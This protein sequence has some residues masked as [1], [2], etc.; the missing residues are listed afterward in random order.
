MHRDSLTE[1]LA[2]HEAGHAVAHVDRG[3]PFLY[4]TIL[5][6]DGMVAHLK[7]SPTPINRSRQQF[8][9]D[10]CFTMLAGVEAQKLVN[11][12]ASRRFGGHEDYKQAR[13]VLTHAGFSHGLAERCLGYYRLKA[14]D[15][16]FRPGIRQS[17]ER[18]AAALLERGTSDYGE[19]VEIC[20]Q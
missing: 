18:V 7:P 1:Q 9:E 3:I 19:V 5:E 17:V 6:R 20:L 15:W 16:L 4:V 13:E 2:F 14:A 11:P 8:A 10:L 12:Y